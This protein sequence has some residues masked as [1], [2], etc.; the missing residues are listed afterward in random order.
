MVQM[1]DR[2]Y[3]RMRMM[4]H[5][6]YALK[7]RQKGGMNTEEGGNGASWMMQYSNVD[8]RVNGLCYVTIMRQHF[9]TFL[10]EDSGNCDEEALYTT[11]QP[12]LL[13]PPLW[14]SDQ[15]SW[16]QIQRPR[17]PFPALPDFSE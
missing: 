1:V 7:V 12:Y 14:S 2:K 4:P 9:K 17:V 11:L 3:G 8:W 13:L 15:S 6:Y 10:H 16:L 5:Y